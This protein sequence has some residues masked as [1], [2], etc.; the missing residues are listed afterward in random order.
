MG[1]AGRTE[2]D[3]AH[4]P[5]GLELLIPSYQEPGNTKKYLLQLN[6]VVTVNA[7]RELCRHQQRDDTLTTV[8]GALSAFNAIVLSMVHQRGYDFIH[9]LEFHKLPHARDPQCNVVGTGLID[10][11]WGKQN[12]DQEKERE[13]TIHIGTIKVINPNKQSSTKRH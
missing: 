10:K 4:V 5:L 13:R 8:P 6:P 12:V 3:R 11:R 2:Y 1:I 7:M 9:Q